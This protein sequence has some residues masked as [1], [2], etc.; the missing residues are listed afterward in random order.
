MKTAIL[1]GIA[2]VALCGLVW[3]VRARLALHRGEP[4][5][6]PGGKAPRPPA[7]DIEDDFICLLTEDRFWPKDP[8]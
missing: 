4:F 2:V 3:W 8:D 7:E 1:I 6:F 5:I